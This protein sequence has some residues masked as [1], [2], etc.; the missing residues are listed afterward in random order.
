M[1]EAGAMGDD[2]AECGVTTGCSYD[3]HALGERQT[4]TA[5]KT[6]AKDGRNA[7]AKKH[8]ETSELRANSRDKLNDFPAL[9]DTDV[10]V[11]VA[12]HSF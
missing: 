8:R 11:N 3:R 12:A 5:M 9:F 1:A 6:D 2:I 7:A 4:T 10:N